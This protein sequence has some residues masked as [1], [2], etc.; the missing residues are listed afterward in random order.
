[1]RAGVRYQHRARLSAALA[2]HGVAF[3]LETCPNTKLLSL[4][5]AAISRSNI[6]NTHA[7]ILGILTEDMKWKHRLRRRI[8]AIQN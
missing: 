8:W 6:R 7:I 4:G 5:N 3:Y 1:M 2:L